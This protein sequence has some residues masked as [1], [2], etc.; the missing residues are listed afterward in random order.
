MPSTQRAL[1]LRRIHYL[2]VDYET[3][4]SDQIERLLV[5]CY[6][7][8]TEDGDEEIGRPRGDRR[9]RRGSSFSAC[10]AGNIA[11]SGSGAPSSIAA[12]IFTAHTIRRDQSAL[13]LTARA[14]KE[15]AGRRARARAS[16]SRVA[17]EQ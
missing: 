7:R 2:A 1:A 14:R 10:I 15:A 13:I 16:V 12:Y 8:E 3:H 5:I 9:R 17:L 11:S 6:R 4:R